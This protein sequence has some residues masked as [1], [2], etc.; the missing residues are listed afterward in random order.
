MDTNFLTHFFGGTNHTRVMVLSLF[1]E[2]DELQKIYM[3]AAT[4]H[5]NKLITDPDFYDAGF[6]VFLPK[7]KTIATPKIGLQDP[8][9]SKF[10]QKNV[11]SKDRLEYLAHEAVD[12]TIKSSKN[13]VNDNVK[14]IL[15]DDMPW[16]LFSL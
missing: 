4:N 6:D 5:N 9:G 1:V 12:K 11:F 2:D 14:K 7:N 13:I 15:F 16:F 10:D 8:K 3:D